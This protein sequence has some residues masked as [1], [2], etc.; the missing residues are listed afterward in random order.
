[1]TKVKSGVDMEKLERRTTGAGWRIS[2]IPKQELLHQ[3]WDKSG[4]YF[5]LCEPTRVG[6][7]GSAKR[8]SHRLKDHFG[9]LGT[10]CHINRKMQMAWNQYGADSFTWGIV[11]E[12]QIHDLNAREQ[13]WINRYTPDRLFN[14]DLKVGRGY[15][16]LILSR[17]EAA[18]YIHDYI[19]V[20]IEAYESNDGWVEWHLTSDTS[21][22]KQF[23]YWHG[24][25]ADGR[26]LYI[27]GKFHK[28]G[29]FQEPEKSTAHDEMIAQ[30][31]KF[32]GRF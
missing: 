20:E 7:I 8:F 32:T 3:Y 13:Y 10:N 5:L 15:H 27:C 24:F 26:T 16:D 4:V 11:E 1:M 19:G 31:Y 21:K 2:W 12:C 30:G 25:Y 22:A 14:V 9:D 28:Y 23:M 6:Y 29:V 18:R 17:D